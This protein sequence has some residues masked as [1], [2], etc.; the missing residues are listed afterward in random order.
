VGYILLQNLG[1]YFDFLI[2]LVFLLLHVAVD[3]ILEWRRIALSVEG[4]DR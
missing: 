2:P 3:R 4:S 1:I